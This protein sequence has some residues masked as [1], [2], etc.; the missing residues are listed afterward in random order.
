MVD[1]QCT[2]PTHLIESPDPGESDTSYIGLVNSRDLNVECRLLICPE[3]LEILSRNKRSEI[4]Y[5]DILMI[6]HIGESVRVATDSDVYEISRMG[7]SCEWFHRALLEAYYRRTL[8]AFLCSGECIIRSHGQFTLTENRIDFVAL[9]RRTAPSMGE[10]ETISSEGEIMVYPDAIYLFP[11]TTRARRLPLLFVDEIQTLDQTLVV[12]LRTG[13]T[14]RVTMLGRSLEPMFQEITTARNNLQ[15]ANEESIRRILPKI[16]Q[17]DLRKALILMPHGLAAPIQEIHKASGNLLAMIFALIESSRMSETFPV[18]TDNRAKNNS[19]VGILEVPPDSEGNMQN[20]LWVVAPAADDR[21]AVVELAFPDEQAATYV[22]RVRTSFDTFAYILNRAF[23]ATGFSR[24]LLTMTDAELAS[25]T[26]EK[27]RMLMI[28]TPAVRAIR[29]LFASRVIHRGLDTWKTHLAEACR[30]ASDAE[31]SG[32]NITTAPNLPRPDEI[33][34]GECE[35]CHA[36]LE[37][38]LRFCRVCGTKVGGKTNPEQRFCRNCG[39]KTHP[40]ERTCGRC[41]QLL[42]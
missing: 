21:A 13:E 5:A 36:I 35:V 9:D 15:N 14:A 41:G 16:T 6:S 28:R 23:E 3:F 20:A 29:R 4:S 39:E 25:Q 17:E 26:R 12:R 32:S 31:D 11:P 38:G 42:G 8:E 27:E 30:L 18:I 40:G 10:S 22:F 33:I 1:Q 19:Y 2:D 24:E 37:P 7:R 34:S